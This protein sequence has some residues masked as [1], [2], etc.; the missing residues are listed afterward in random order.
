M[1]AHLP[2]PLGLL[3]VGAVVVVDA[4]KAGSALLA[5]AARAVEGIAAPD[6]DPYDPLAES[7]IPTP[8]G[9]VAAPEGVLVAPEG[10]VRAPGHP[11]VEDVVRGPERE[12]PATRPA[13]AHV[14]EEVVVVAEFADP[15]AANGA[16]AQVQAEEPWE[17]YRRLKAPEVIAHLA[18]ATPDVLTLVLGYE[19]AHRAR[20]TV[21][22]AAERQLA[23]R[24]AGS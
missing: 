21:L 19:R 7:A 20:R 3:R 2:G 15:G 1:P 10:F 5:A 9:V 6:R 11:G 17:G 12:A 18:V 16:G 24:V 23:R 22:A 13:P 14:D 8:M 4:L